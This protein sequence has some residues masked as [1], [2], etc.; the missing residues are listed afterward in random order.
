[1]A[2]MVA[3]S[4]L[5]TQSHRTPSA[6]DLFHDCTKITRSWIGVFG[7]LSRELLSLAIAAYI[8]TLLVSQDSFSLCAANINRVCDL[9]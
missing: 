2:E 1:M 8:V 5:H 3:L 6:I 9:V 7:Q 4:C